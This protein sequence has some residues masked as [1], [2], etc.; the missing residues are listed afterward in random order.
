LA[1]GSLLL[2]PSI[3]CG[4][5][6]TGPTGPPGPGLS[7]TCPVSL[8]INSATGLPIPVTYGTAV[9]AGGSPPVQVACAPTQGSTFNPGTTTVS[10]TA[11]DAKS[12]SQACAF[13]VTVTVPPTL[14]LTRFRAF[15]DSITA[16]EILSEG[17][18]F[19][20]RTLKVDVNLAY[21][22]DLY[23]LLTSRYTAQTQSIAVLN[24]GISGE[25]TS[26][27][28]LRLM[29]GASAPACNPGSGTLI[30]SYQAV[31]LMEGSNDVT[32]DDASI[33]PAL[34]NIDKMVS[35]AKSNSVRVF[36]ASIPPKAGVT[37]GCPARNDGIN[38]VPTYN[39]GLRGI[40]I[41]RGVTFVD[42]YTDLNANL[43]VNIDC[44]GLHPT[45]AGYQVIANTFY[46]AIQ[47]TLEVKTTALPTPATLETTRP[48]AGVPRIQPPARRRN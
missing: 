6:P 33:G 17:D 25:T 32:N 22:K 39:N 10:C 26:C 27:G 16:G 21:P 46:R 37:N 8:T 40:A 41:N 20:F 48:P 36:L 14:S 4:D 24:D 13:T 45:Q 18:S 47:Q 12:A 19:G 30:T 23:N 9:G 11:T 31:L 1:L 34:T 29:N 5:S 38:N 35:Y 15:G 28:A 3:G 7:I 2:L 43:S 44:D 42:V